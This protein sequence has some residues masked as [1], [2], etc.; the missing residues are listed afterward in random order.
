MTTSHIS[1]L[2]T[3]MP[4]LFDIKRLPPDWDSDLF[5]IPIEAPDSALELEPRNTVDAPQTFDD[6][7]LAP[8]QEEYPLAKIESAFINVMENEAPPPRL[9]GILSDLI[10]ESYAGAP[11]QITNPNYTPP[12][13]SLAFYNPFHY[14]DESTW[15]VYILVEGV[16]YLANEIR[17]RASGPISSTLAWQAARLFLYHHEAFHHKTECFA[18]RLEVTHRKPLFRTGFESFYKSTFGTA[19]CLEEGLAEAEGLIKIQKKLK[20]PQINAALEAHVMAGLPGYREG[21]RIR[22]SFRDTR[23]EFA[24]K[25]QQ[26]CFPTKATINHS[27]WH[28][29]SYSFT[30]IGNIKSPVNYV[31]SAH[32]PFAKR[33][34]FRPLLPPRKLVKKLNLRLV[35]NGRSHD[36]Y[37][38]ASGAQIAIPRHS[39]DLGRGLTRK[40]I[41]QAG[42]EMGLE[43]FLAS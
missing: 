34:P 10:T 23:A 33:L 1:N 29:A 41:K 35:R 11:I 17:R 19:Q 28:A 3:E 8:E 31:I 16:A 24:E 27:V 38:S 12:T 30:G 14:F 5:I 25:N 26:A 39:K 40:I 37:E 7:Q 2:R 4:D 32:S 18:T 43:K 42:V 6:L 13:D 22:K 20:N 9:P 15:G 21:N 36:L